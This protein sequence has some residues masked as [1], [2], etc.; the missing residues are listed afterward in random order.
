MEHHGTIQDR[1]LL[2]QAVEEDDLRPHVVGRQELV[3]GERHAPVDRLAQL[4]FF[5][6]AGTGSFSRNSSIQRVRASGLKP[7]SSVR[8]S[9]V[10]SSWGPS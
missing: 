3:G 8:C 9:G 2:G 4:V 7:S 5:G 10:S 6:V 1:A